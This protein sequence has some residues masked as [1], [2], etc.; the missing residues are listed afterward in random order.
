MVDQAI[1]ARN[2]E[3]FAEV[4]KEIRAAKQQ[5]F[6]QLNKILVQLYWSVGAYI[7]DQVKNANWGKSTVE[8]LASFIQKQES[9]IGG[10]SARN[11]WRMKQFYETYKDDPKLSPLGAELSWTH[12]RR[13][14]SLKTQEE[15]GVMKILQPAVAQND[16]AHYWLD[17][18]VVGELG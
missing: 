1:S 10:F 18:Y 13:I 9:G 11:I 15:R 5:S 12:N 14:M 3:Q 8:Q 16:G 6:Q 17:Q 2:K 4:L 7:S